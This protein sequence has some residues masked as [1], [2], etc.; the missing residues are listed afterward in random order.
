V[1]GGRHHRSRQIGGRGLKSEITGYHRDGED[2]WVAE[3][4]CGH[5]QHVRHEPP[6]MERPWVVTA[7]G[8]SAKLG[9]QLECVKCDAGA[10]RDRA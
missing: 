10:P 6:W 4:R 9:T 1:Q 8:R 5:D 2:H 7:E 3:L